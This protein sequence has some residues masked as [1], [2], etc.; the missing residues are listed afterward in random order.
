M[1][2]HLVIAGLVYLV[3]ITIVLTIK[4]NFMF[5][6]DGVWKE[7]GIGR[8]PATYTWMPFW[9]F[10]ILWALVSYILVTIVLMVYQPSVQQTNMNTSSNLLEN[11]V[12][13]KVSNKVSTKQK[14]ISVLSETTDPDIEVN[15]EEVLNV[16]QEDLVPTTKPKIRRGKSVELP[17]GY[18]MLNAKASEEAGG[19]PK[20]IFLGKGLP[21]D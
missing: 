11:K 5:T 1:L 4:P 10:A 20:Y 3:G 9:L 7:F 13:N 6:E 15:T 8:N 19:I 14:N 2:E 16:V 21:E 17:D 18:Y 12:L